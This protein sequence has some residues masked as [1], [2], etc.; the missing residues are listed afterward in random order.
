MT[1]A[2]SKTEVLTV[3]AGAVVMT[4]GY[5]FPALLPALAPVGKLLWASGLFTAGAGAVQVG[6]KA[7]P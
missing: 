2:K 1:L 6:T 3:L 5:F 7:E 4:L